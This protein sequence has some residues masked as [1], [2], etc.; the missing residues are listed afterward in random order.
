MN[1]ASQLAIQRPIATL[2][3]TTALALLGLVALKGLP[4]APLPQ[5]DFPVISVNANLAG[6][7]PEVMASSVATPLEKA[8]GQL[9]GVNEITSTS[10]LGKTSINIQFD[11]NRDIDGA[12]R[13]VQAAIQAARSFLPSGMTSNPTY[14]KANPADAPIMVLSLT[15]DTLS[16]GQLF[17]MADTILAQR[18]AQ[19]EGIGQVVVGGGAS[20]AIRIQVDSQALAHYQLALEDVRT[21][22]SNQHT[23]SPLGT[24]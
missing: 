2:L 1:N 18:L 10:T 3:L 22:I 12:A 7:S 11:L 20:P 5:V 9:A 24:I 17:D 19:I 16:R 15:S 23:F 13:D 21:V 8:L 4:A 14:K 6:A